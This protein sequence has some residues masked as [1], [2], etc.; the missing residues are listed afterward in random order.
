EVLAS[1][2]AGVVENA[3]KAASSLPPLSTCAD[4]EALTS[5]VPPPED[6]AVAAEVQELREALARI[7][8]L[9]AAGRLSEASAL[10]SPLEA[11]TPSLAYGPA[12]AEVLTLRGDLAATM[13]DEQTASRALTQAFATALEAGDDSVALESLTARIYVRS[14]LSDDFTLAQADAEIA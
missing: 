3:V 1:A 7:R 8:A 5:A 9:E 2:D 14:V 12:L 11:L 13:R 10:L 4:T 6:P